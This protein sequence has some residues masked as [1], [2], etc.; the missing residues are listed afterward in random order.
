MVAI[1]AAALAALL[2]GCAPD[3]SSQPSA[4]CTAPA[5]LGVPEQIG[6]LW[7][8]ELER[9]GV[10]TAQIPQLVA[11]A[12]TLA[13]CES[14]WNPSAVAFAGRYRSAPH[15]QTGQIYTQSGVFQLTDA[16]AALFVP[17]GA[18]AALDPRANIVGAAR[19]FLSRYLA[20][21]RL[22][23]FSPWPCAAQVLP[24]FP[25]APP[26]LPDWAWLY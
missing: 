9:A 13:H 11:D 19:L 7:R 18:Q 4:E 22:A 2:A 20:G 6:E 23:G 12:V 15:P 25:A 21:G 5:N 1:T 24:G 17:G 8:C 10:P 26:Q 14:S 16:D 3:T